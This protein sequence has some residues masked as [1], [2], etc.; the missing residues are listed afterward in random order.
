[1]NG[2]ANANGNAKCPS[3]AETNDVDADQLYTAVAKEG[4]K[5]LGMTINGVEVTSIVPGGW[6][7]RNGILLIDIDIAWSIKF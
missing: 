5:K 1:M 2:N 7:E 3:Q 4:E 6:G